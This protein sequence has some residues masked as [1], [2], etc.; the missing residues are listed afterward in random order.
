MKKAV[1]EE[2]NRDHAF[3]SIE[4]STIMTGERDFLRKQ[5]WTDSALWITF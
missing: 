4:L 2:K 1:M 3:I 5:G